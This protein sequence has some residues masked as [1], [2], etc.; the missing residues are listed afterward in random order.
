[1]GEREFNGFS[2]FLFL[3]IQATNVGISDIWFILH[4]LFEVYDLFNTPEIW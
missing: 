3:G 4:Q 2:D 1:M